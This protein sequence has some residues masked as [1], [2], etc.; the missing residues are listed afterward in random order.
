MTSNS[1]LLLRLLFGCVAHELKGRSKAQVIELLYLYT[2][3]KITKRKMQHRL[4]GLATSE[5]LKRALCGLSYIGKRIVGDRALLEAYANQTITVV[6]I[7][8]AMPSK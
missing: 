3:N 5:Q 7:Q 2:N 1:N 4:R 6:Q 8:A